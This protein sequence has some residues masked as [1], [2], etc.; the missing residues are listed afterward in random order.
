MYLE[1]HVDNDYKQSIEMGK[2]IETVFLNLFSKW[3]ESTQIY[4]NNETNNK[5]LPKI[6]HY[7]DNSI[8]IRGAK[9]ASSRKRDIKTPNEKLSN[10]TEKI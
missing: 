4:A 9:F 2:L 1:F 7:L 6:K 10:L 3:L 5:Q 8:M